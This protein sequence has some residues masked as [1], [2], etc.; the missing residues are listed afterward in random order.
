M[1]MGE[2]TLLLGLWLNRKQQTHGIGLS[3]CLL[4]TWPLRIQSIG[5]GCQ[6]DRR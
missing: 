4:L 3:G 6:I 5:R 1:A 2:C